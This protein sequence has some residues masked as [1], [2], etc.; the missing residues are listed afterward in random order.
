MSTPLNRPSML[1]FGT[2]DCSKT[3]ALLLNHEHDKRDLQWGNYRDIDEFL[4]EMD[5][6]QPD[7]YARTLGER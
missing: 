6:E 1:F 5:L 3:A 7:G 2:Q 4:H